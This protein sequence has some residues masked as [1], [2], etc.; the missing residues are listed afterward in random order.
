VGCLLGL[1]ALQPATRGKSQSLGG[2][3]NAR[4]QH[5]IVLQGGMSSERSHSV[6]AC[7]DDGE[8]TGPI[9]TCRYQVGQP[10]SDIARPRHPRAQ[11]D[12]TDVRGSADPLASSPKSLSNVSRI[13]S[14]RA[15]HASMSESVMPGA[16]IRAQM[17]SCPAASRAVTAALGKFS[18]ARKRI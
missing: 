2:L 10:L 15:A 8:V 14:W 13:R 1:K 16:A 9:V 12:D 7:L 6:A 18:L 3:N 4:P 5:R 11:Q 17:T